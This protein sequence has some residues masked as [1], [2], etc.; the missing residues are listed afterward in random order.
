MRVIRGSVPADAQDPD[1]RG[2]ATPRIIRKQAH[3]H[4]LRA[5]A[6]S[7]PTPRVRPPLN[8][9]PMRTEFGLMPTPSTATVFGL[10]PRNA[11]SGR[12]PSIFGHA[13]N[14][15]FFI[16]TPRERRFFIPRH[17]F[18][19]RGP[20][21]LGVWPASK[22]KK[23]RFFSLPMCL[24]FSLAHPPLCVRHGVFLRVAR[25]PPRSSPPRNQ[26]DRQPRR[27]FRGVA[28]LALR[29][30]PPHFRRHSTLRKFRERVIR[31]ATHARF[32]RGH[33]ACNK[34]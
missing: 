28:F 33:Y 1:D 31:Y 34:N 24:Y 20:P 14:F 8:I 7:P 30:P 11:A 29:G 9:V 13:E 26:L 25:N 23:P 10:S 16:C 19:P 18:P 32:V 22:N 5:Y 15:R 6:L 3:A 17:R 21:R 2:H 12:Q 27:V 4:T